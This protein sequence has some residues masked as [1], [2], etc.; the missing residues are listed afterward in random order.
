MLSVKG[1]LKLDSTR[2]GFGKGLVELGKANKN[3]VVLSADLTD[4]VRAHWFKKEFPDRF[5]SFGVAEQNM[6]SAAAGFAL[7]GKI[8]YAATFGVFAAGRAWDQVRVS[9]DYMNLNVKIVGTHAGISVGEDGYTHQALEEITLMR[10]LPNMTM[11]VPSDFTEAKRAT[12][13]AAEWKGPVYIRLGRNAS[14]ILTEESDPFEIGKGILARPGK[15]ITI[16]ACGQMFFEAMKAAEILAQKKI[17]ARVINMHTIKP[18]DEAILLKAAKET[19][20]FVTAEEHSMRGGLGGAVTEILSQ[21]YPVPVKMVGM[22]GCGQSG[23]PQELFKCFNL[24]AEDVAR[25]AEGALA[26]KRP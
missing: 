6:I 25:A 22:A 10:V 21:N 2:N 12:L 26:M 7:S 14:P 16:V 11:I 1:E 15:D 5:F 9:V 23:S 19:G 4:S 8:A 24:L 13:K 3:I 18:I 20:A 17:D